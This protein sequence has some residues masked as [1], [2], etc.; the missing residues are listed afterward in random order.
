[1]VT[2][3]WRRALLCSL[4]AAFPVVSGY[5]SMPGSCTTP[6]HGSSAALTGAAATG[7]LSFTNAAGA[8]VTC[9]APGESITVTL[10]DTQTFKGFLVTA[11]GAASGPL[12]ACGD[13]G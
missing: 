13:G 7:A 1:M 9:G 10:S 5:T 12:E 11:T 4:A 3:S 8:A 2:R 6:S